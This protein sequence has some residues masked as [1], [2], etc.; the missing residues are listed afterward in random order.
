[1][2]AAAGSRQRTRRRLNGLLQVFEIKEQLSTAA[3][4]CMALMQIN[5]FAPVEAFRCYISSM[6]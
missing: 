4:D 5:I 1:V 2:A 3:R 6:H